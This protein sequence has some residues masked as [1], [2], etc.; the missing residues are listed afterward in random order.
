MYYY[1]TT[2]SL[3]GNVQNQVLK[4][5]S[6]PEFLVLQ[7]I[8]GDDAPFNVVEIHNIKIS[9]IE[10]KERLRNLYDGALKKSEQSV[11]SIFGALGTLP[12]RLPVEVLERY[13]IDQKPMDM[14]DP[15]NVKTGARNE[16]QLANEQKII[17][18]DEVGVASLL[19]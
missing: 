11:S 12:E 19:E 8:H 15:D 5:V 9:M 3:S 13:K 6:A 4:T 17:S 16:K 18:A 1:K 2:L 7:Y 14:I 10:E